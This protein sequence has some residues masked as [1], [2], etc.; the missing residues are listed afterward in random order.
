MTSNQRRQAVR[1]FVLLLVCGLGAGLAAPAL[2]AVDPCGS[3]AGQGRVLHS[4]SVGDTIVAGVDTALFV[5]TNAGVTWRRSS[6]PTPAVTLIGAVEIRNHRLFAGTF[7]QGSSSATTSGTT[8]QAFNQGLVGGAVRRAVRH[9]RLRSAGDSIMVATAGSGVFVRR[10]SVV[11]TWH[12][13]GDAFEPNQAANVSD[14]ALGGPTNVR[15][16]ACAGINGQAFDR[17]PGA[18][19]WTVSTFR[20]GPLVPGLD[21]ESALWTGTR[22]VVGTIG[23]VFRS[24]T[25]Q[26]SWTPAITAFPIMK[27]STLARAGQ[28]VFIGFDFNNSFALSVS[29]D[30][31]NTWIP[32]ETVPNTFVYQLA[33][34]GGE[35]Y[36][37]RSDGLWF[38]SAGTVS[39]GGE[40]GAELQFA[41]AGAQPVHDSARFHF[42][43]PRAGAVAIELFDVE[44]RRA[45]GRIEGVFPAGRTTSVD[46]PPP[47]MYLARL[48]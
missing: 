48:S 23:G 15:L 46:T 34:Q 13:F 40:G 45:A 29:L 8:W 41:L 22:W 43:L 14:L 16:F 21:A 7:G 12:L 39:V 33:T 35:L 1:A 2:G 31:G 24:P 4:C 11:D 30:D 47:P 3:P 6:K 42:A 44:G 20:N 19:D 36:A 9:L 17:D 38:R 25:G 27:Q 32:V 28:S 37:A 26:D 18:A 10:L 5:S